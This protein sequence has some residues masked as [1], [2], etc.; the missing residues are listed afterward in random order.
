[1]YVPAD[2]DPDVAYPFIL[3]YHGFGERGTNNV[4]QVD[5]NI[6]GLLAAAKQRKA[7]LY[8]PQ[9]S[10]GNWGSTATT[11]TADIQNSIAMMNLAA[12]PITSIRSGST[13]PACRRAGAGRGI[14]SG[15]TR[16]RSRPGYRSAARSG[17]RSIATR[18]TM[19]TS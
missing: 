15:R 8:A 7:F 14:R 2:Y 11:P 9:S 13:S 16:R 17:R 6:D 4:A 5:G 18:S 3:F 10:G 12:V 1:L 19:K